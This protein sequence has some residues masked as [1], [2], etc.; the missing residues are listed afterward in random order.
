M[1][2][3]FWDNG[4]D[5]YIEPFAGSSCF[6][7]AIRPDQAILSDKNRELIE[8]YEVLRE[9]PELLHTSLAAL[10][11]NK[12]TYYF[13]RSR[14]PARLSRFDRA[15]RFVYLNR[16]CFNGIYRTNLSGQFNV[17]FGGTRTGAAISRSELTACADALGNTILRSWDFGTTLRYA[18][19]G[20]FVYMD[21]PYAITGKRMFREYGLK[22][23]DLDDIG[24][25]K[26]H[27]VRLD[28][29]GVD[30]LVSYADSPEGRSIA[31][32]WSSRRIRV[33]RQVAGFSGSRRHAYELLITNTGKEQSI[34]VR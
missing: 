3:Q 9:D 1:L 4:Y 28:G 2:R 15:V 18:Q 10:P 20:D 6:F 23:F 26:E 13:E 21:P 27:L 29:R 8:A 30:F 25:L 12:S 19:E 5:R 32:E 24:R 14:D 7:F 11:R 31:R 33:G 16:N 22:M 17:P 34:Y